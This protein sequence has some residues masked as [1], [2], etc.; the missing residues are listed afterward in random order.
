MNVGLFGD[1]LNRV[2][3]EP[4]QKV[5]LNDK[6][7]GQLKDLGQLLNYNAYGETVADLHYSPHELVEALKPFHSPFEF[8]DQTE[9]VDKLRAGLKE[10]M[11][12]AQNSKEVIPNG[13][14]LPAEKWARRVIGEFSNSLVRTDPTKAYSILVEKK[15]GGYLVSVRTPTDG[16]INVAEFCNH[17][18]TGGG[19]IIA[20]GINHLK[21]E[22]VPK[23]F[24]NF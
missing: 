2:A 15:S 18:K 22:E 13:Y 23:F 12:K 7:C 5:G 9:V 11:H 21:K 6:Q 17:F 10:D 19:R 16:S 1:N 24:E 3:L 20:A 4:S 8:L 14:L